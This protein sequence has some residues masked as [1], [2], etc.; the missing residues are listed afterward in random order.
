MAVRRRR[1]G[2]GRAG[3]GGLGGHRDGGEV[4]VEVRISERPVARTPVASQTGCLSCETWV[5]VSH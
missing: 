2:I 1:V 5:E 4:V 3:S